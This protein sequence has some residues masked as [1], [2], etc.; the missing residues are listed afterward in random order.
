MGLYVDILDYLEESGFAFV[1]RFIPYFLASFG[2]HI[3]NV[4]NRKFD[5]EETPLAIWWENRRV[6]DMRLPIMM[7]APPTY[8][9]STFLIA[10]LDDFSGVF[11]KVVETFFKSYVTAAHLS[12]S[13]STDKKQQKIEFKGFL[14][15]HPDSIVGIEEFS[16][17]IKASKQEHSMEMDGLLLDWLS[18]SNIRKGLRAGDI[19][20]RT[21]VTLW[22][23]TQLGRER[24]ELRGG[25]ARRFFFIL[26]V[27]TNQDI[28]TLRD[29]IINVNNLPLDFKELGKLRTRIKN[30]VERVERLD[31]IY[32]TEELKD[33]FDNNFNPNEIPLFRK[34]A[35][36]YAIMKEEFDSALEVGLDD[37][38]RRLMD[39]SIKWRR[40]IY[41]EISDVTGLGTDMV[42]QV[43][44]LG[45]GGMK[46]SVLQEKLLLF[47]VSYGESDRYLKSLRD[48]KRIQIFHDKETDD[49]KVRLI[50]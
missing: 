40:R 17:I 1:R 14:E 6:P 20:F 49:I 15:E 27:P 9:K 2:C 18:G 24:V 32:L 5:D 22:T 11:G 41:R 3:F 48:Q 47:E 35:I 13:V 44:K 46:L 7:I 33:Y 42:L 39:T 10:L 28:D 12:G 19:G 29:A 30:L 31:G 38:L 34:L 21:N 37:E 16:S 8:S 26:W 45:G 36:G 4:S 23:G 25:M 43:L 50:E